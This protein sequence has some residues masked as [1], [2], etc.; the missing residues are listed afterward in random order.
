M[1]TL[2]P[3]LR[4]ARPRTGEPAALSGGYRAGILLLAA[5]FWT[6]SG[7]SHAGP[8][9]PPGA[10]QP[11]PDLHILI[12]NAKCEKRGTHSRIKVAVTI[13]NKTGTPTPGGFSTRVNLMGQREEPKAP[14]G[15]APFNYTLT[16]SHAKGFTGGAAIFSRRTVPQNARRLS[17]RHR[18]RRLDSR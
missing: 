17:H 5:A 12:V 1:R 14:N 2:V 7:I 3:L 16:E 18:R 15:K 9:L 10:A 11:L 13:Q 8:P 4:P 6:A